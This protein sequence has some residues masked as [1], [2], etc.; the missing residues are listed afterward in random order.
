MGVWAT[1]APEHSP[2]LTAVIHEDHGE[3]Y[4]GWFESLPLSYFAFPCHPSVAGRNYIIDGDRCA[5]IVET[6]DANL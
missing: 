4:A 3:L 1:D 6:N 2:D 5:V